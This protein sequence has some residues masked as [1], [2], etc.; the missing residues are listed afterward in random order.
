MPR[1]AELQQRM[2]DQALD[3]LDRRELIGWV[4]DDHPIPAAERLAIHRN[5]TILGLTDV[6]TAAFPVVARLV[7]DE[8]FRMA[9]RDFIR[10]H[11]PARA[12]LLL[13]GTAFPG[14]LADYAPAAAL[15]YLADVARLEAAW[16]HAY[17]A[18]E[19][20]PLDPAVLLDFPVERLD[21]LCLR[22]HP[23][24][25]F[26]A[27]D[28]PVLA[29]WRANQPAAPADVRI[30]LDQGGD[31]LLVYRPHTNVILRPVSPGAFALIMALATRQPVAAAHQS[32]LT[33][34]PNFLL[35]PELAA[36]LAAQIFVEAELS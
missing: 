30:D 3:R 15:P 16:N 36:L 21:G 33:M 7:G 26:V 28:Y 35:I 4:R 32:A 11:P 29:I 2:C 1:L 8:F 9:A 18:A 31:M 22:P 5:N 10:A 24:L 19:A 25:R 17:H 27:S 34:A 14:F 6:L 20:E 13:Y 12:P 23:S